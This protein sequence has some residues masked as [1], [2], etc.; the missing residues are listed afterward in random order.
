MLSVSI[1]SVVL[2]IGVFS[3]KH[4]LIWDVISVL[5]LYAAYSDSVLSKMKRTGL[6]SLI[7][8]QTYHI[9]LFHMLGMEVAMMIMK[10]TSLRENILYHMLWIITVVVFVA[11][12]C[13][14][15]TGL[16]HVIEKIF[17]VKKIGLHSKA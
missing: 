4:I 3:N 13:Y 11:F 8:N 16:E 10:H 5:L 12:L 9:Y 17:R 2:L 15:S 6:I 7:S 14:I 1:L